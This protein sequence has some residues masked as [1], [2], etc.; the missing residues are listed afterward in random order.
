MKS[1]SGP[2]APGDAVYFWSAGRGWGEIEFRGRS[3]ILSVRGGELAVSRLRLPTLP[4]RVTIDG[5]PVERDGD[6]I[7]L[8]ER[9]VLRAGQHIVVGADERGEA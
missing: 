8:G 2:R 1:A 9:R 3:A 6:V 4:G 7:L 5:R